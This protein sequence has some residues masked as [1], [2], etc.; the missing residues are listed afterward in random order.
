MFGFFFFWFWVSSLRIGHFFP[1][2]LSGMLDRKTDSWRDG[3]STA[4]AE[5]DETRSHNN[6]PVAPVGFVSSFFL[7]FKVD[8][9]IPPELHILTVSQAADQTANRLIKPPFRGRGREGRGGGAPIIKNQPIRL[10]I[11]MAND[12]FDTGWGGVRGCS[13]A[14]DQ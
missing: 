13:K 12:R 1:P 6:N 4:T 11:R 8:W 14:I 2:C 5:P 3:Q 10:K 7:S 9:P